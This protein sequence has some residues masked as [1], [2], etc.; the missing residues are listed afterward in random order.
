MS[1]RER[2]ASSEAR[3]IVERYGV[4]FDSAKSPIANF[5]SLLPDAEADHRKVRR[6]LRAVRDLPAD[7]VDNFL[8]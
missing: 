1:R 7:E 4:W 8:C 2:F 6:V 5:M 3:C